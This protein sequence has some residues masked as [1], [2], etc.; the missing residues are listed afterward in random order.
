MVIFPRSV[1]VV[2]EIV[3]PVTGKVVR[4]V[5]ADVVVIAFNASCLNEYGHPSAGAGMMSSRWSPWP[6]SPLRSTKMSTN[7]P[8]AVAWQIAILP[9][10]TVVRSTATVVVELV[11]VTLA[12][13]LEVV[14]PSIPTTDEDVVDDEVDEL[15]VVG[16]GQPAAGARMMSPLC[17][18]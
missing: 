4:V 8:A 16:P 3:V 15:V 1:V 9:A 6:F 17:P 11:V 10:G 14:P 12:T 2:V 7:V 18:P 13:T 5:G